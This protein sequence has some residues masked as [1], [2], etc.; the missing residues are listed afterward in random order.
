MRATTSLGILGPFVVVFVDD[1]HAV[2][3]VARKLPTCEV[4]RGVGADRRNRMQVGQNLGGVR[5]REQQHA[6]GDKRAESDA[7][8][9]DKS[10]LLM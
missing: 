4:Q 1:A 3:Q 2:I 9:S 5:A 10:S 6:F 7:A 8:T